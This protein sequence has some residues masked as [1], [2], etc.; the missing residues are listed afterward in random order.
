MDEI[1]LKLY[2]LIAD[3]PRCSYRDM[4]DELGISTPAVHRR[5][6]TAREQE[7]LYGPIAMLSKDFVK[8][9]GVVIWGKTDAKNLKEVHKNLKDD[10]C[11]LII[12]MMGGNILLVR[13]F[14]KNLNDL[15]KYVGFIREAAKMPDPVIG[16]AP[17]GVKSKEK[18]Y[19]VKLTKVDFKIMSALYKDSR[20]SVSD[21]SEMIKVSPKTVR[22][23]IKKIQDEGVIEFIT[24][25]NHSNSGN[26]V[27][28]LE[29]ELEKGADKQ[30]IMV[31]MKNRFT[32]TIVETYTFS[33]Q[34]D[35]IVSYASI[36][37]MAQL[38]Q[39]RTDVNNIEG[40]KNIFSNIFIQST[41]NCIWPRTIISDPEKC[42]G[43][44]QSKKII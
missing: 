8:A 28:F 25:I 13:S 41:G 9:V 26:F 19:D 29:L 6:Q 1:D 42:M 35:M 18:D 23:H 11:A 7:I 20:M 40:V 34:I 30:E 15:D 43:F 31:E 44:L 2:E 36:E 21:I 38:E 24:T 37:N 16:L 22:N 10:D 27:L 14:L 17:M 32:P 39:L 5:V 12:T 33:N 3:N 4:A